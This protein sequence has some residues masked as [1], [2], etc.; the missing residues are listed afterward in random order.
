MSLLHLQWSVRGVLVIYPLERLDQI[1]LDC[2]GDL[3]PDCSAD[4]P[5]TGPRQSTMKT[6]KKEFVVELQDEIINHWALI[7]LLLY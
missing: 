5:G 4:R 2:I 1:R 6:Q 7:S 3:Q